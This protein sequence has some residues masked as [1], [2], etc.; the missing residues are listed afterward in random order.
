MSEEEYLKGIFGN[1]AKMV[2]YLKEI[3]DSV[4]KERILVKEEKATGKKALKISSTRCKYCG[5]LISWQGYDKVDH[6]YPVHV[7]ENGYQIGDGSC[8]NLEEK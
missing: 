4:R 2:G 3:R 6:P 7:D 1:T 8:P 5:G